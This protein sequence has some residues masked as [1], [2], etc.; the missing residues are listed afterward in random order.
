M[1]LAQFLRGHRVR[2]VWMQFKDESGTLSKQRLLLATPSAL[3]AD[4]C[5]RTLPAAGPSKTSSTR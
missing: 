4:E 1:C 5:S 3:S 2:A